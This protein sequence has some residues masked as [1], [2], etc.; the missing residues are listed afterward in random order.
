MVIFRRDVNVDT[1]NPQYLS[2]LPVAEDF[3]EIMLTF[4]LFYI[5]LSNTSKGDGRSLNLSVYII[6]FF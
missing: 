6:I 1:H 3:T 5:F 4:H 2:N